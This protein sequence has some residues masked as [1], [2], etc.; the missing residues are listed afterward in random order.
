MSPSERFDYDVF[1]SFN[2]A[3]GDWVSTWLLPRLVAAGL[4]VC[5]E[6]RDF[7]IGVPRLV[8]VEN[9]VDGSRHTLI[10]LSPAWVENEWNDF[11]ALL[12]Q[13]ADPVGRQGRLLPL[14]FKPCD[15]PPRINFLTLADF[16][17][18]EEWDTALYYTLAA[19]G[20]KKQPEPPPD[21]QRHPAH[22]FPFLNAFDTDDAGLFFGRDRE[23]EALIGRIERDPIVVVNGLSGCGKSSLIKAGVMPRLTNS[24][25]QVIYAPILENVLT[26]TL[27]E[28]RRQLGTDIAV[29]DYV[30]AL[31][32]VYDRRRQDI[33]LIVDQFEHALGQDNDPQSLAG[34][35]KGVARLASLPKRFV[36]V[37]IVLRAD[38]LYFLEMS[39]RRTYPSLNVHS[40]VFTIDPL[41]REGAR[42]AVIRPLQERKFAYNDQ[43]VDEIVDSLQRGVSGLPVESYIQPV[44]LQMVLR[45]LFDL[46][47]QCGTL[48]QALMLENYHRSGGVESI[49]RNYLTNSFRHRPEA[50]RLLARFIAPDGKAAR[51]NKRRELLSVPAADDIEL[52]LIFLID[53]G[54]VATYETEEVGET[55]YRLTHDYL[56]EAIVD[57]LNKNPDQQ[58]WKLADEWLA[59]GTL[60]WK[61]SH[62]LGRVD[63]LLLEQGR[64]L[65]IY[66][67]RD[68]LRLT[69]EAQILLTLTSLRYGH[70]GLGYWLS[71]GP[72]PEAD[73]PVVVD[74]LLMKD[75][76]VQAAAREALGGSVR[77]RS[78]RGCVLET[79][80][81]RSLC[82]RLRQAM[83]APAAPDQRDAAARALWVLQDFDDFGQ[84]FQIGGWVLRRWARDH[85]RQI[86]SYVLLACLIL[87]MALGVLYVREKLRGTWKP[88]YSLKSGST[89]I[90]ARFGDR[91]YVVTI[92]GP[93]PREGATLFVR[94]AD[95]WRLVSRDF[96]KGYPTS[97]VATSGTGQPGFLVAVYGLGVT[98][99]RD[100]GKT[101]ELVTQGLPSRG[102]T[103]LLVDPNDPRIVYAATDDWRGVLRSTDGGTSWDFYD[104]RGEMYGVNITGLA[105]SRADG[106]RLIAGTSD[107]RILTHSPDGAEWELQMGLSKGAISA[108]AVAGRDDAY[109]YAGTNRGIVMRST[110]GGRAWDILGQI[111]GEF[112]IAGISVA[113]DSPQRLYASAYGYGGYKLWESGDGGQT[114][115]TLSGLGLPRTWIGPPILL[116]QESDQMFVSGADGLFISKDM[117]QTWRKEPLDAPLASIK[118]VALSARRSTPVYV[119]T[120]GSVFANDGSIYTQPQAESTEW[121]Y[122]KGLEA[123]LVR[124]VV[125]DPNDS[126][127]AYAGVMMLGEWSVFR[128]QDGG[129]SWHRTEAPKIEPVV[130]DT[131]ALAAGLTQG[132][133]TVVYAG[134]VGCGVFRT[135]DQG[136]SWDTFGRE[137]CD[138]I[139][140]M[141][142]DAFFLAVDAK[143]PNHVYSAA[144]QELSSSKDGGYNWERHELPIKSPIMGLTSDTVQAD[145]IYLVA[146][147]S[148]FWGSK[149]AGK[150]WLQGHS[151]MFEGVELSAVTAVPGKTGYL[152]IGASNGNIWTTSDGGQSWQS[153]REKL[154]IG[155]ITSIAVSEDLGGRILVGTASDGMAVFIPGRILG[156][157]Q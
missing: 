40:C 117:G 86:L 151:P 133:G 59:S 45:S 92:G 22:M 115:D 122:G 137:R 34:F 21:T 37:V 123:E 130:P 156:W 146:G 90:M 147:A 70:E 113:P 118:T 106:G 120:G 52:E 84:R 47:E 62:K 83:D 55:Y 93:G 121:Q 42:E 89:L 77:D 109:V 73:L 134:T 99:S 2:R 140:T 103:A 38:W 91:F 31:Q 81:R 68:K 27:R 94:E 60:E 124:T 96:V 4:S 36:T 108:L 7:A 14:L 144:G 141:P 50:W 138:Q 102:L 9:A 104:P 149:D 76:E 30:D 65:H 88:I 20:A 143:D 25:Y 10:V 157:D 49:L 54:F 105:Y 75:P 154:A 67:Y 53:Q 150:T 136:Q 97:M 100:G 19:M 69:G 39:T 44:Q 125:V 43:V 128:T 15:L 61:E 64:Y 33:V 145:A 127:V 131:I 1:I 98:K 152:V 111:P 48:D 129:G 26:D 95:G 58:G 18:A 56:V 119:A 153:I 28:T 6:P 142:S 126:Q 16:T 112:N 11:A 79:Q 132:G 71:R 110:D 101:W 66:Q 107:G 78:G 57:Y 116:E 72:D 3:D 139:T 135:T 29:E 35:F 74:S 114:W 12:L 32:S 8:N 155:P 46:A 24:G 148:G 5:F 63:P 85:S 51:T 13:T 41:T 87:S 23:V 17:R 80:P 82:A